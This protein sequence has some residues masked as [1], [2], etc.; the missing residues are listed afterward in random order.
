MEEGVAVINDEK[1]IR[2]GVCHRACPADAVRHDGE[3][4][5]KEVQSNL[6]WA[7]EL[8]AHEYYSSDITKRKQLVERLQRLFIKNKKVAGKTLEQL[9]SLQEPF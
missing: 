5:P 4:I 7:K 1:C 6:A 2:C 9:E 3:R 8:L